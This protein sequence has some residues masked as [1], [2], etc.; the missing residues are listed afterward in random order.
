MATGGIMILSMLRQCSDTDLP[1]IRVRDTHCL[2][3]C[4]KTG[5]WRHEEIIGKAKRVR[6][7]S[8]GPSSAAG[9]TLCKILN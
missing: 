8:D 4:R 5:N 7:I 2:R 9:H 6:W 1:P 3:K